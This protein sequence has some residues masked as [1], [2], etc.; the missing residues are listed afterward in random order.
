MAFT[1]AVLTD[2]TN[3]AGT[4][5]LAIDQ[6]RFSRSI[7]LATEQIQ[8][9]R[10]AYFKYDQTDRNFQEGTPPPLLRQIF[11]QEISRWLL[12]CLQNRTFNFE[13]GLL[14]CL[15]FLFVCLFDCLF[16]VSENFDCFLP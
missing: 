13:G 1:V 15:L 12:S 8:I 3:F 9:F 2:D 14:L 11:Q 6:Y 4:V 5:F 7:F 16:G 10:E